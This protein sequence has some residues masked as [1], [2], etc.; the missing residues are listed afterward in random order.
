MVYLLAALFP[1]L[2]LLWCRK[3]WQ[4]LLSFVL[5]IG[6]IVG[7]GSGVLS[8]P[9]PTLLGWWMVL[10]AVGAV[11]QR[12]APGRAARRIREAWVGPDDP[13]A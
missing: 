11:A 1:P 7:V 6:V 4:A 8:E 10:S 5:F 12:R 9:L 13:T 3:P 2:T